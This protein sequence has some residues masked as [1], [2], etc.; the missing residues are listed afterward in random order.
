MDGASKS[1]V[2][3]RA[4]DA[5]VKHPERV[6]MTLVGRKDHL[7]EPVLD[8]D[9]ELTVLLSNGGADPTGR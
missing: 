6:A 8:L 7:D 1:R 9:K 4:D 5:A 3:Q 2:Q